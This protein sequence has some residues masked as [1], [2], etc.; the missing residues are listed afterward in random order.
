MATITLLDDSTRPKAPKLEGVTPR[1]EMTGRHLKAVHRHHLMQMGEVKHMMQQV[2]AD[3]TKLADLGAAVSNLQMRESYRLFGNL[4]GQECQMLNFHHSAE[5]QMVFPVLHEC[6]NVGIV[7][8]VQR[9][10]QEHL[11]IHHYIEELAANTIAALGNPGPKSFAILRETFLTLEK[12]IRSHFK[13][14]ETELEQALG[15]Y[16]IEF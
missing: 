4:C 7:Q 11:I 10:M 1:Q 2:E 16:G 13:Y 5:D 6:G 9:L 8:V 14:E 12:L 15:Y 3:E